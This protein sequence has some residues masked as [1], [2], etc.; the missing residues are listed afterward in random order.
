M[1]TEEVE[2]G[3]GN[4]LGVEGQTGG[5]IERSFFI[6]PIMAFLTGEDGEWPF[7]TKMIPSYYQYQSTSPYSK[8]VKILKIEIYDHTR[9]CYTEDL[10]THIVGI[11][12]NHT[13]SSHVLRK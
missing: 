4:G 6:F 5:E 1:I 2:L 9:W 10:V 7:N 11:K 12:G 8:K 3:I 13:G